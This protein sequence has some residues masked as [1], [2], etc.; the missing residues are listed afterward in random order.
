MEWLLQAALDHVSR[1]NLRVTTAG[2]RALS[3]GDGT[4]PLV[5]VRFTSA[6]AQRS[7]VLDPDL[8]LGEAYMDGT[9]V[10]ESGSIADFFELVLRQKATLPRWTAAIAALRYLWRHLAQ[11]NVRSRSRRNVAHHYDLDG[12]LYALFLDSDRQYSCAY[13]ETPDDSLDDAQL[14]KKRHL[15]AKLMIEKGDRL[16]DIG[17]GWGGLALY[18]AEFC[19][20]DVT[21]ITL[22]QEQLAVARGRAQE[23]AEDRAGEGA[24]QDPH[25]GRVKF[26]ALD[27]RDV[28]ETYDRIVSVG[29]FEHVGIGFYDTF[30]AK[31][32]AALDEDGVMV[33]HS[34]GRSEGPSATNAWIAKYVFPGGYIP[35]LSEVLPAVERAGLLVTDIEI[36]RLHYA[37]TLKAWRDRFLAHRDEAQRLFDARFVRMWEYYLACSESAFRYQNLMVFQLQ[38]AKRQ[39]VVPITR[40]YIMRAE[41]R[42]RALEGGRHPPLRL[43]GE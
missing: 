40:D 20:A 29:M 28:A 34:I 19:G 13:F 4:G 17:C 15:A 8:R 37:D 16:L 43:A 31:C 30:F 11:L 2:G 27:Y 38:L 25:A 22:S 21:G 5:A 18:A 3:F 36:L 39:G 42:L 23:R 41:A 1:G 10:V 33:L 9:F 7:V 26:R 32:A 6:A 12:Q 14:A 24:G 35:A